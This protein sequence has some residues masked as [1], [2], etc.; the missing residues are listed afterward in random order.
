[1]TKEE[2][3]K[4]I[5]KEQLKNYN[6]YGKQYNENEVGICQEN[7]Y[8][9]VYATD[10]RASIVTGSKKIFN[11]ESDAWENFI[12]RLKADKVLREI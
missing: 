7:G 3:I 10:E 6:I 8:W 1:M 2:A 9:I 4:I 12:K 5:K 11:N